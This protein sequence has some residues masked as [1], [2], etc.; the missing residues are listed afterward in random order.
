MLSRE[1][2]DFVPQ[3]EHSSQSEIQE[4]SA[5]AGWVQDADGRQ[6]LDPIQNDFLQLPPEFLIGTT[7]LLCGG[8]RQ[9]QGFFFYSSPSPLQRLDYYR[10]YD[11][12]NVFWTCVVRTK[13][14]SL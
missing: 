1:E 4:V 2:A 3:I 5:T 8:L 6:F 12:Q 14:G 13:L 10:L 9:R 11:E 7:F